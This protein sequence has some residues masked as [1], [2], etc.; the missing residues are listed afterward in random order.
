MNHLISHAMGALALVTLAACGAGGPS[1]PDAP[2][3]PE[4]PETGGPTMPNLT[5]AHYETTLGLAFNQSTEVS[6]IATVSASGAGQRTG[7]IALVPAGSQEFGYE[8]TTNTVELAV[9]S[10]DGTSS[11]ADEYLYA[12]VGEEFRER[13]A[14][15][16]AEATLENGQKVL[17]VEHEFT[18]R[19]FYIPAEG[20]SLRVGAFSTNHDDTDMVAHSVFGIE[21]EMADIPQTGSGSFTGLSEASVVG[22]AREGNYRGTSQALLDFGTGDFTASANMS[23]DEMNEISVTATG[24]M[25]DDGAL[26]SLMVADGILTDGGRVDGQFQGQLFGAGASDLGGTFSGG[27]GS[28]SIAGQMIMSRQD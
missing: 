13:G 14:T 22:G 5:D 15:T 23:S 26:E 8:Y 2:D 20:S 16:V 6:S 18:G 9:D 21:T 19:R 4:V 12:A 27:T 17:I 25:T 11:R 3:A 7:S 10:E 24:V 1:L 28:T